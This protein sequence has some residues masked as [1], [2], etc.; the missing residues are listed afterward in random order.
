MEAIDNM[1]SGNALRM[2]GNFAVIIEI[3]AINN[4]NQRIV[5]I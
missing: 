4:K 5:L 2:Q 3:Q 1:K